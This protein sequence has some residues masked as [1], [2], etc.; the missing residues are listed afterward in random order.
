[1]RYSPTA[2]IPIAAHNVVTI[3]LNKKYESIFKGIVD[4]GNKG[5]GV[6]RV[7]IVDE[8]SAQSVRVGWDVYNQMKKDKARRGGNNEGRWR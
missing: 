4:S 5:E 7:K 2:S 8:D 1:M 3:K 6:Q